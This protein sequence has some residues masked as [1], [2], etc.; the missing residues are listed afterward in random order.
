VTVNQTLRQDI[1]E[2]SYF[3]EKTKQVP[4]SDWLCKID[5]S[6]FLHDLVSNL[7]EGRINFKRYKAQYSREIT[8]WLIDNQPEYLYELNKFLVTSLSDAA[9]KKSS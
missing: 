8:E 4:E 2:I 7:S 6:T 9:S 3:S 1:K 5:G